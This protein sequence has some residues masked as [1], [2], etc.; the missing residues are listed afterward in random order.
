MRF[1]PVQVF[2]Y[3]AA[4]ETW[5]EIGKMERGRWLHA[6]IEL[7]LRALCPASGDINL[8]KKKN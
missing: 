8:C 4:A 6:L 7:N 3:D 5:S 1:L 2:E